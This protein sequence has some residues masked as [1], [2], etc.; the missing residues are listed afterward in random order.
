[1]SDS[2][3]W[4][5][6]VSSNPA[7]DLP[8]FTRAITDGAD[9]GDFSDFTHATVPNPTGDLPDF[10]IGTVAGATGDLPDFTW[11]VPSSCSPI[12]IVQFA[13]A[14]SPTGTSVTVDLA[15]APTAGNVLVFAGVMYNLQGSIYTPA[16][17]TGIAY[18]I[19]YIM[20]WAYRDVVAGDGT[21][22]GPFTQSAP[23]T[24]YGGMAAAAWELSGLSA[25]PFGFVGG[26]NNSDGFS[27]G[28]SATATEVSAC[29]LCLLMTTNAQYSGTSTA[30]GPTTLATT[31]GSATKQAEVL[32]P[33]DGSV[34]DYPSTHAFG[35]V[36]QLPSAEA[37]TVTSAVAPY[38]GTNQS[39]LGVLFVHAA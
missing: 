21:S 17:V 10:T 26:D 1:M 30:P 4:T 28:V 25:S 20:L 8:D 32:W 9:S 19:D 13:Y 12:D 37:V 5:F 6:A 33:Q 7:G 39:E 16:G 24:G 23:R 14:S 2:A 29:D 18:S 15:K 3:D 34:V 22:Y 36:S 35:Y 31:V 11:A 38:A 27:A